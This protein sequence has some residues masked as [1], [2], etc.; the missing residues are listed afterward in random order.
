MINKDERRKGFIYN[1]AFKGEK[2]GKSNRY[3]S[4]Y[5]Q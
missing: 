1:L 4:R 5:N 3:R 2:N